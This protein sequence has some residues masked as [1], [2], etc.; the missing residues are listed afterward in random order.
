MSH[1]KRFGR[2]SVTP[3]HSSWGNT[4]YALVKWHY[5]SIVTRDWILIKLSQGTFV[6]SACSVP[7]SWGVPLVCISFNR[8]IFASFSI[9]CLH[10]IDSAD[11][12]QECMQ[13]YGQC[14]YTNHHYFSQTSCFNWHQ[15]YPY[16][17]KDHKLP[18]W[19][20]IWNAPKINAPA[21]FY[22]M[23]SSHI[24][25]MCT[26]GKTGI[27]MG[28]SVAWGGLLWVLCPGGPSSTQSIT[29]WW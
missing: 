5:H 12:R 18:H 13:Q 19:T 29:C 17:L 27:C 23:T 16:E 20:P 7:S 15:F 14:M 28:N 26:H 4:Y 25:I 10:S 21:W 9:D 24:S 6:V 2:T 1:F 11:A 22:P 3:A 8:C